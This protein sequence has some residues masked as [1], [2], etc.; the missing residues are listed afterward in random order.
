MKKIFVMFL[1]IALTACTGGCAE[2]DAAR[3]AAAEHGADA[4]DQ[5]LDTALW[6]ICNATPVG[7]IKRRFKSEEE[8][9]AYNKI[10]PGAP[11]P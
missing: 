6:T 1:T 4:A 8:R 3:A 11:L 10:C 5:A 9:E 7:A 2:F